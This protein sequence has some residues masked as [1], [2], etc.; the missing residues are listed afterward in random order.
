HARMLEAD[1]VVNDGRHRRALGLGV[2]VGEGHGDLLVRGQHELGPPRA[3]VVHEGVVETPE[4]RPR[5]DGDVLD[6]HGVE[7]LDH[8]IRAIAR[9]PGRL[10]PLRA[11]AGVTL[12]SFASGRYP[13]PEPGV[14]QATLRGYG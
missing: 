13:L 10:F 7:E 8:E 5:I 14:V 11:Q 9:S 2:A 12:P 4:R 1:D 3:R 6:A